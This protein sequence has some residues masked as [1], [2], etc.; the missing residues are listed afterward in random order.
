MF[1]TRE[2][3]SR[4]EG[5]RMAQAWILKAM[6]LQKIMDMTVLATGGCGLG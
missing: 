1:A 2:Q 3:H 5:G 6:P 4:S